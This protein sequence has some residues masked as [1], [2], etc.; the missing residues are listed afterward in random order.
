[1]PN[2]F[3]EQFGRQWPVLT[4]TMGEAATL[5]QPDGT[6]TSFNCLAVGRNEEQNLDVSWEVAARQIEVY[7]AA[8]DVPLVYSAHQDT[9]TVRGVTY[10][11]MERQTQQDAVYKYLCEREDVEAVSLR[12]RRY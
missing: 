6:A 12:G 2:V 8:S 4:G 3:T 11:V 9:I 10:T 5:T 7:A 1:M